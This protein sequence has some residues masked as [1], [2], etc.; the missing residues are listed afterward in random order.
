M[1]QGA[2]GPEVADPGVRIGQFL[3]QFVRNTFATVCQQDLSAPLVQT[4]SV[5][6]GLTGSSCIVETLATPLDCVVTEEVGT[7]VT[8]LPMCNNGS[9]STNKPCWELVDDPVNCLGIS[10]LKLIVQRNQAPDPS[11]VI[12]A[13]CKLAS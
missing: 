13:R 8:T 12:V 9:S 11:A 3:N 4:A 2:A 1:Y 6:S 7:T 10:H 5:I